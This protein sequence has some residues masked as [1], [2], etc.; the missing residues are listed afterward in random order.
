[1]LR[2]RAEADL[3]T[4]QRQKAE[5]QAQLEQVAARIQS[6]SP[7][8]P[9][10]QAVAATQ[11][12]AVDQMIAS[13]TQDV[14]TLGAAAQGY[15]ATQAD[16]HARAQQTDAELRRLT[17]ELAVLKSKQRDEPPKWLGAQEPAPVLKVGADMKPTRDAV[18]TWHSQAVTWLKEPHVQNRLASHE[19][20]DRQEGEGRGHP[21]DGAAS[22]GPPLSGPV[23]PPA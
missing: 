16:Q 13:R 23:R 12:Q 19:G 10:R 15:N 11:A 1:M 9:A 5:V 6:G 7:A 3:A 21:G 2:Q 22:A 4:L 14:Q 8:V 20:A 18:M 17:L